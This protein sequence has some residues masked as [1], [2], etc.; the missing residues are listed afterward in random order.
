MK[1][2]YSKILRSRNFCGLVRSLLPM[3][4]R[5]LIAHMQLYTV[6]VSGFRRRLQ[7][8]DSVPNTT[9]KRNLQ[10]FLLKYTYAVHISKL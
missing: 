7:I 8:V 4:S 9:H 2:T 6:A 5:N 10:K 3:D 1:M